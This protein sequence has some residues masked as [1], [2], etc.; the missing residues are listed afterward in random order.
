MGPV[1]L[2]RDEKR[3]Q[4]RDALID[5]AARVFARQGF[6]GASLDEIA[7]AAGFS[8]GAIYSNFDSKEDLFLQVLDHHD[9]QQRAALAEALARGST[10]EERLR[11]LGEW[12]DRMVEEERD[13]S[14]LTLEFSMYAARN[15]SLREALAAHHRQS[16]EAVADLIERQS[17]D[18]GFPLADDPGRL[19]Q[20]VQALGTGI[21]IHRLVDPEAMANDLFPE[22]VARLLGLEPPG[23]GAAG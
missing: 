10:L 18:L 13:W 22:A 4:T 20:A 11:S 3:A 7:E 14:L 19:A 6:H 16:K 15:P 17:A 1:R 9:R 8:K 5:A 12:F 2:T 21:S 23:P